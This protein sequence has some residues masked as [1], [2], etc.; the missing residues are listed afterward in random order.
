MRLL[1]INQY[2]SPDLAAT[3]QY[4]TE[5]CEFLASR[6]HE[7]N[8]VTAYPSYGVKDSG[9]R[10]FIKSYLSNGVKVIR[11]F[12]TRFS[13]ASLLGRALNY[14]SF[15]FTA[16]IGALLVSSPD[17]VVAKTD[18]PLI[19][20]IGWFVA[21]VKRRP[22]VQIFA[23]VYPE[24]AVAAGKAS[25]PLAVRL[26]GSAVS[27]QTRRADALVVLGDR[28]KELIE[29]KG[30]SADRVKVLSDW[31]DT[32]AIEPVPHRE[33]PFRKEAGLEG[34]FVVMHSGNMGVSQD[35]ETLLEAASLLRGK[36]DIKFVLIGDGASKKRLE[37]IV[38]EKDLKNVVFMPYQP[39]DKLKYS[40][41]AADVHYV[42]LKRGFEGAI[43]PCKIYGIMAVARPVVAAVGEKSELR[44]M[45]TE[46]GCGEVC[47]VGDASAVAVA[48]EKLYADRELAA[49]IGRRGRSYVVE[50]H[51]KEKV[52]LDYEKLFLKTAG[53][54]EGY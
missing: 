41:S 11:T 20:L 10:A 54:A 30:A 9:Q 38:Q 7:V 3:G 51:D 37:G 23:D 33:N 28:M 50:R 13:R 1:F 21:R 6:G 45:V 49:E 14:I 18:P 31:V 42:S 44:D 17:L 2:Y 32:S 53:R 8:V 5:M 35:L 22:Y 12:S 26:L 16:W 15:L 27:F 47:G 36:G 34:S 39:K 46:A 40:L 24:I 48:I 25:N 52:L 43:V 29:S 19:G 4:L